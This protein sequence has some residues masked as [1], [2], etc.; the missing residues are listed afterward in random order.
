MGKHLYNFIDVSDLN[1]YLSAEAII[2]YKDSPIVK[3][4]QY[5]NK[6]EYGVNPHYKFLCL[7]FLSSGTVDLAFNGH[8]SQNDRCAYKLNDSI[9]KNFPEEPINVN[10]G[11]TMLL[12]GGLNYNRAY[13]NAERF[14]FTITAE[15]EISG[16]ITS[17]CNLGYSYIE[18]G[19][20]SHGNDFWNHTVSSD[21]SKRF[22][23]NTSLVSA[24]N[25]IIPNPI[26]YSN[27]S[28]NCFANCTNLVYGPT[29]IQ[30]QSW[31]DCRSMFAN[32]VNLKYIKCLFT[33]LSN[34][35]F[36]GWMY[37]VS[38]TGTFIKYP[39]VDW[40]IGESGIP[41]GWTILESTI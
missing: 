3:Y 17:I 9:W 25:L 11:D 4:L 26:C 14:T 22:T 5:E 39:G 13:Y 24:K 34:V 27:V 6:I 20:L 2:P 40:P 21:I 38:P 36:G 23:G 41:E 32:C 7:N 33:D 35:N 10:S 12:A 37:N 28:N 29:L 1:S 16:N 18:R 15:F 31:M 30:T 19:D 8:S